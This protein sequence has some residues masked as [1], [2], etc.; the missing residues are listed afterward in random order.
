MN[1]FKWMNDLECINSI[2]FAFLLLSFFIFS[3]LDLRKLRQHL[4][5]IMKSTNPTMVTAG[6]RYVLSFI[7]LLIPFAWKPLRDATID[8][9][10]SSL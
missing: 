5:I 2:Y 6:I 10:S 7:R 4:S 3:S 1:H 9:T 8:D